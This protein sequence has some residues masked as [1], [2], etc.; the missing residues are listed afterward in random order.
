[1]DIK[2]IIAT[3]K[4]LSPIQ[5]E[6]FEPI[7]VGAAQANYT[8]NP[9]YL[10]DDSGTHLSNKNPYYNELTALFWL[11]KNQKKDGIYGLMHYR[12]FLHLGKTGCFFVKKEYQEKI[13]S[14]KV[15]ALRDSL[16]LSKKIVHWLEQ[17]DVLLPYKIRLGA[18]SIA[19]DYKKM[20]ISEDWNTCMQVII[21]KYP[22][23]EKSIKKY[24]YNNNKLFVGNIFI[25]KKAWLDDYCQWLF[26]ILFEV[27]RR[28]TISEDAY[29]R[30]VFGFLSERLL[31]LYTLH[32][33]F[34]YK[35][36]PMIFIKD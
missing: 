9:S 33:K 22:F 5:N 26:D 15:N 18:N 35:E 6:I 11:W 24:L 3:H 4:A 1:M 8:I 16:K 21:E 27:E 25:S 36:L 2:I 34:R 17:Y 32:K 29:Q 12:R 13:T 23:Y 10:K 30:R 14:S 20:H 7:Q 31:T 19:E 28:I